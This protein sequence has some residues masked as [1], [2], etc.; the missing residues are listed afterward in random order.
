MGKMYLPLLIWWMLLA[1]LDWR[2]ESSYH[3]PKK[4]WVSSCLRAASGLTFII[5]MKNSLIYCLRWDCYYLSYSMIVGPWIFLP[6]TTSSL[7]WQGNNWFC[8]RVCFPAFCLPL[9][10]SYLRCLHFHSPGPFGNQYQLIYS[11]PPF[12]INN[13]Y[14]YIDLIY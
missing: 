10:P 1:S 12:K 9:R 4:L 13:E 2:I 11:L 5:R 8:S 6:F 3:R 14:Y 7:Y